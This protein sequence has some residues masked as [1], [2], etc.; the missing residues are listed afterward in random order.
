MRGCIGSPLGS[1]GMFL[2]RARYEVLLQPASSSQ[3]GAR[4]IA[5]KTMSG[6]PGVSSEVPVVIK[7]CV[8]VTLKD[9]EIVF[10]PVG[11][12]VVLSFHKEGFTATA[13]G[14]FADHWKKLR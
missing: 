5:C 4:K 11:E 8:P 10:E 9:R 12:G 2:Q 7:H 13:A 1:L 3:L 6:G 14:Q